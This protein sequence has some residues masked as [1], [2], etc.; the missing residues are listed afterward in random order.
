VR[1]T[2]LLTFLLILNGLISA[3]TYLIAKWALLELTPLELSFARFV[4]ASLGYLL[5]LPRQPHRPSRKDLLGLCVLGILMVA[6]FQLFFLSGLSWSSS[7]HAALLFALTPVFVAVFARFR[8]GEPFHPVRMGGIALAF[9]G[10]VLVLASRGLVAPALTDRRALWGDLLILVAVLCWTIYIVFG[11][12]YAERMGAVTATGWSTIAGTLLFA[13]IGLAQTH[14][15]HFRALSWPGWAAILYLGIAAS[16]LSYVIN[17]WALVRVDTGRVAI[18]SNLQPVL[19]AL[20]SW[21]IYG[22][23]LTPAFLLGGAMVM[24][25]VALTQRAS[26]LAVPS[27][28]PSGSPPT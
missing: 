2:S 22:E 3:G 27:A 20:L 16:I 7:G 11:K 12:P 13:P 24:S 5:L 18:W 26:G 17:Y 1:P 10:V 9:A 23:R 8:L 19:T 14:W 21:A 28:Q 6:I 15:Q 25:G 4:V